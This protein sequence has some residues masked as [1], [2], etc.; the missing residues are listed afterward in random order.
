MTI[1]ANQQSQTVIVANQQKEHLIYN[2]I[3]SCKVS[4]KICLCHCLKLNLI[5]AKIKFPKMKIISETKRPIFKISKTE[6]LF[7]NQKSFCLR[8]NILRTN[9]PKSKCPLNKILYINPIYATK[10][11]L[12]QKKYNILL[13]FVIVVT[14]C[15]IH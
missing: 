1:I 6:C 15:F 14:H 13:Y 4:L 11:H 7:P 8:P 10:I 3:K 9:V 2:A 5:T 12:S